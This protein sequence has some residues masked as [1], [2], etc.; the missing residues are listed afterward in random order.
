MTGLSAATSR[1]ERD[2]GDAAWMPAGDAS[3]SPGSDLTLGRCCSDAFGRAPIGHDV[4]A[5]KR[6]DAPRA[7]MSSS[8]GP[9]ARFLALPRRAACR[10][11]LRRKHECYAKIRRCSRDLHD[12]H[13]PSALQTC[14]PT[15]RTSFD[16]RGLR[17][18]SHKRSA[19]ADCIGSS[20]QLPSLHAR[21]IRLCAH[22]TS[23]YAART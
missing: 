13:A 6:D 18:R 8:T 23:L 3:R 19:S 12:G 15:R 16:A 21:V 11:R 5:R 10:G 4:S 2:R 14:L 20:A 22:G 1:E 17:P 9:R 7:R